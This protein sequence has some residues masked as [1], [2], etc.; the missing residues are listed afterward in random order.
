MIRQERHTCKFLRSFYVG[1]DSKQNNIQ[2]EFHN[3]LLKIQVP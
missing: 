1:E 2:A 3:G